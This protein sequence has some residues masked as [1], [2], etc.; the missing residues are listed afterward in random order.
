MAT[1]PLQPDAALPRHPSELTPELLTTVLPWTASGGPRIIGI[2]HEA[3]GV[4][5]VGTSY[6]LHLQYD[7]PDA[8]PASIVGKFPAEDEL[9]LATAAGLGLYQAEVGFYRDIRDS[10]A[11]RAPR[12]WHSALDPASGRFLLLLEDM[13]PARPGNQ[14][15]GC[16]LEDARAA[17]REAAALH[18]PR[19]EDPRLNQIAWMGGREAKQAFMQAAFP[20]VAAE[21]QRRYAGIL[22]PDLMAVCTGYAARVATQA[23]A[24]PRHVTVIHGDFRLD[25]MLFDVMGGREPVAILD[26]QTCGIGAGMTDVGYFLGAGVG[27]ELRRRHEEELLALYLDEL[28]RHGVS[29]FGR[30]QAWGDYLRGAFHGVSTAMFAAASVARTERG[31]AMFLSMAR[32][33][34]QLVLDHDAFQVLDDG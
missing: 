2:G 14:L 4:G 5:M 22:E 20:R 33:A 29:D 34:C 10:V 11:V 6:R 28:A 27:T 25:N 18:G 17:I 7:T 8:G 19:W 15:T 13:G 3:I 32:G 24:T 12:C 31:D 26:W 16:T 9:S 1:A 21:F 23:D 30:D